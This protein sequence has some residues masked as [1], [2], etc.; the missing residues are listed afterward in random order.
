VR[1]SSVK[2]SPLA[3]ACRL[4]SSWP[5]TVACRKWVAMRGSRFWVRMPST[6]RAPDSTSLQ[7]RR[8]RSTAASSKLNC[9]PWRSSMRR[10]MRSICS[11][12]ICSSMAS[13]M[14]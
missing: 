3:P 2:S 12:M 1:T 10:C 4:C 9:A 7:R 5:S 8:T 11:R 14:G 6:M 13:E